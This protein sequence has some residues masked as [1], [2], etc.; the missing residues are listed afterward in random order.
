MKEQQIKNIE[1]CIQLLN[2]T[3]GSM[4]PRDA[5]NVVRSVSEILQT[6]VNMLKQLK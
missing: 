2:S 4:S 6:T 5:D 3:L 1:S